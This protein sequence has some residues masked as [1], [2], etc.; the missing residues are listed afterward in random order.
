MTNE[1]VGAKH[2][3][4]DHEN[5]MGPMVNITI[6]NVKHEIHRGHQT[7][8]TIKTVGKV[9]LADDLEEVVDKKLIPLPDD[10]A[11]TLKGGEIF[12]SHPKD[13]GS[14]HL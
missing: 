11:I 2:E 9:P 8:I 12:V 13:S 10:G 1:N 4:S 3:T 14:S 5:H 6:N 7:V